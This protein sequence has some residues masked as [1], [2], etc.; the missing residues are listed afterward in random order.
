MIVT[1]V[2][3]GTSQGVP[4]IACHCNVCKSNNKKD[5]RLRSSIHIQCNDKSIVVD[6]GPDFRQQMLEN[7][8]EYLDA[9]LFT[10]EHKDHVAGLDDVRPYNF[11]QKNL[12]TFIVV[13]ECLKHLKENTYIYLIRNLNTLVFLKS[14]KFQ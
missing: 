8:I 9:V 2:G 7:H 5:Y 6:T 3:S 11:K 10:H 13:T 1:V 14:I 12:L 4:V